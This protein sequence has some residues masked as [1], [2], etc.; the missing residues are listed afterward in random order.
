MIRGSPC[1]GLVHGHRPD[2]PTLNEGTARE[3]IRRSRQDTLQAHVYETDGT[4]HVVTVVVEVTPDTREPGQTG[5]PHVVRTP[6]G[7]SVTDPYTVS[8]P[9]SPEVPVTDVSL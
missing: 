4:P 9:H 3:T 1:T 7:Q 6:L 2:L 5:R 8:V